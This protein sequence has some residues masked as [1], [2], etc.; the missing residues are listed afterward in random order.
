M[1]PRLRLTVFDAGPFAVDR[2][3][4][5]V[6]ASG[7]LTVPSTVVVIEHER[8]GVVL[9]DTG[10]NHRVADD[11][12]AAN[13]WGPGLRERY[14]ATGFTREHS[15]D[16]QLERLGYHCADVTTVVYSHLHIDHAGGMEHFPKALHVVQHEELRHAWW[17][18][19]WTARGYA[20]ADYLPGRGFDYL[21]LQGD[22][23]LFHDGSL[24]VV[25]LPGHTPG[26]QGLVVDLPG[27]GQVAF[28]GDAA[29]VR[30][31][32]A[33]N[34]PQVSDWNVEAKLLSYQRLRAM[35]RAGIH[36]FLSHDVEDFGALP[37]GGD[38]WD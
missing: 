1:A 34:V 38:Y 30:E 26:S 19:R 29:H 33:A 21:E 20:L 23:D 37:S 27:R 22:A 25:R 10:V 5:M 3:E 7:A 35:Q 15:V 14:G 11:E 16:A 9:F 13:Q 4:L 32:I 28:V 24:R 31:Q 2:G 36:V 12:G 18:D 6:G 8:H 17:P